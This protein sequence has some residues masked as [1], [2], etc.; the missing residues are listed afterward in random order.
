M[1]A[2]KFLY[3]EIAVSVSMRAWFAWQTK[4][5]VLAYEA[6]DFV[7]GADHIDDFAGVFGM[8]HCWRQILGGG[9]L[10]IH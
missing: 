4:A 3:Q 6:M 8:P 7:V 10:W 1:L 5:S 2:D 9:P